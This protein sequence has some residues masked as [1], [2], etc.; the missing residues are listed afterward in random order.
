[1]I[2][3][4]RPS[5]ERF[6]ADP[7]WTPVEVTPP[8]PPPRRPRSRLVLRLQRRKYDP[9]WGLYPESVRRTLVEMDREAGL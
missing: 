9:N 1:M 6:E 5:A 7:A 3:P 8:P 2:E 4:Y